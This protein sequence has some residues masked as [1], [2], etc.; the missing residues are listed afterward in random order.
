MD[1]LL[2]KALSILIILVN[3]AI[4]VFSWKIIR[5]GHCTVIFRCLGMVVAAYWFV[6]YIYVLFF[7]P[8]GIGTDPIYGYGLSLIR[9]GILFSGAV[10]LAGVIHTWKHRS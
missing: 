3:L 4:L 10:Y 2:G 7:G 9:P 5:K 1:V 6:V 8:V